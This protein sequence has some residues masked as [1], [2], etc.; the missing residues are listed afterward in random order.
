VKRH[1]AART[2]IPHGT[3]E[4]RDDA[5]THRNFDRDG[6]MYRVEIDTGRG[7]AAGDPVA[8]P[9][10][11]FVQDEYR[12]RFDLTPD[13]RHFAMVFPAGAGDD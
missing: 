2:W 4:V 3:L 9:I 13:G 6:R 5:D 10:E 7:A 12:R 11:G 8:L 1:G